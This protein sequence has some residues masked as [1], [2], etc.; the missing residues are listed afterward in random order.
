MPT[1]GPVLCSLGLFQ[2]SEASLD[3]AQRAG[4]QVSGIHR[5]CVGLSRDSREGKGPHEWC[6]ISTGEFGIPSPPGEDSVGA[7]SGDRI[8]W[9]DSRFKDERTGQKLKK[10]RLEAAKIRDQLATP[11][12]REVSCLLGKFNSVSKAVPPGPLFSRALQRD[13]AVALESGNQCYETSC[14]LSYAAREELADG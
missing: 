2:D 8:P 12:A 3:P 7:N 11:T 10:I 1:I 6:D 13:L 5:R 4:C 14:H 9:N